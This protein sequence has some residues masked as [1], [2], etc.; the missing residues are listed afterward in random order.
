MANTDAQIAGSIM[1]YGLQEGWPDTGSG[2]DRFRKT[3]RLNTRRSK[4]VHDG[5]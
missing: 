1:F 3:D 5:D 2:V 4:D